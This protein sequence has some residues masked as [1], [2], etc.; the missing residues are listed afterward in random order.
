MGGLN[1]MAA[2]KRLGKTTKP[3]SEKIIKSKKGLGHGS[4]GRALV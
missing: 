1:R 3:Y 2:Q 4:N